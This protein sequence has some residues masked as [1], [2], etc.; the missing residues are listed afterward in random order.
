MF[1]IPASRIGSARLLAA[2]LL[3]AGTAGCARLRD[4]AT[5]L[6]DAR[7]YQA[8]GEPKAAIIQVK[9][10]LQH[11]PANGA[12]RI[13]LG[14]LYLEVGDAVS[15]ENELQ[16]AQG[17]RMP[18]AD[19]MPALGSA[20]VQQGH[21][22][23]ALAQLADDPAQP[24][25]QTVRGDAL[26]GLQRIDEARAVFQQVLVAQ[27]ANSAALLGLARIAL[28]DHQP[29][30]ALSLA[31]RA[32]A[33]APADPAPYRL[34]G[35]LLRVQ[36]QYD[37]ALAA[38][39]RAA[40]LR[41]QLVQARVDIVALYIQSGKLAQARTELASVRKLAPNSPQLAY[42]QA[43][44]DF[45]ERKLAS[46]QEQ[47]QLVLRAAPDHM[48]SILLMGAI[49][50]A[51]G[52]L[53]QSEQHLRRFLEAHPGHRYASRLLAGIAV[54]NGAADDALR[55]LAPM[56][57]AG[58][59]DPDAL[60]LAGEAYMRLRQYAKATAMYERASALAPRAATLHAALGLSRMAMGE[61]DRALAELEQAATMDAANP[62]VGV[63][64]AL[65]Q[66]RNHENS[67]ALQTVTRME[68]QQAATPL[69]YNLKGGVLLA[70]KDFAGARAS[71]ERALS[72]DPRSLAA[73]DNLTQ[74]DLYEHRPEQARLRLQT[75]LAGD[76]K[77]EQLLTALGR[78][79]LVEGQLAAART[80]LERAAS[81]NPDAPQPAMVL[82]RFYL[83][84]G[85][86]PKGLLLA[87]KLRATFP[88][89]HEA[90]VLLA[91][92][93]AATGNTDAA[94]D[95]WNKLAILQLR[96]ASVQLRIATA[97]L[98]LKQ[99]GP[100]VHSL[101]RAIALQP[102]YPEAQAI[103][104][105]LHMRQG[106]H[107][108]ALHLVRTMQQQHP[109]SALPLQL[110]GDILMLQKQP[111]AAQRAYQRG[112]DI[113]PSAA[114]LIA[115][116]DALRLAGQ[117]S[118]AKARLAHWLNAHPA[119]QAV[120][121]RFADGLLADK[122]YAGA[123]EQYNQA[124]QHDGANLLAL[125]NLAWACQQLKDPRARTF[126]ERAYQR[127]PHNAA[128]LDTLAWILKDEGEQARALSLLQ[129]A[130]AQAPASP[131]VRYHYAMLLA[132]AGKRQAAREQFQQLLATKDF[133]RRGEVL[134][135]MAK[136]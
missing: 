5:L 8:R 105:R 35:D 82:A 37:A 68:R 12:A 61:T 72:L 62:R 109:G 115:L 76:Q 75:A 121:M 14:Q 81:A 16:R 106:A 29:D 100:A 59:E 18:A 49:E 127:A 102:D 23:Q 111:A 94:L 32:V 78:L 3:L 116:H 57:A 27:A 13:L 20:M 26:L 70:N 135:M 53:P 41:P 2:A 112:Y 24:R 130:S 39:R 83:Q 87:Q 31:D 132:A 113:Q 40:A 4:D 65:A 85:D 17:L 110:E 69:L 15:A 101:E 133:R 90:L 84:H 93:Q 103:L 9:N 107:D 128:V 52:A 124:V 99:T 117:A 123:I 129:Q 88:D 46:A 38:Y 11:S 55:L 43:L 92:A 25:L 131:D 79:A 96:S 71:F 22:A 66:L 56:L 122:D 74:L 54:Q 98:A 126:A 91:E 114:M 47:L 108:T 21:Y 120:R 60:A 67:Q 73:L 125:N 6:A 7:N 33:A 63:L 58:Q 28:L 80:W 44:I 104:A 97:E 42:Q 19:V 50:L 45:Q 119:D 86:G 34:R 95:S 89:N 1:S 64:L 30:A 136:W 134:A 36:G 51:W 118:A 10:V 77:N 48:P